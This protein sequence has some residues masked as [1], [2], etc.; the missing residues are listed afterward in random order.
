MLLFGD[1]NGDHIV[2]RFYPDTQSYGVFR[3]TYKQIGPDDLAARV[4]RELNDT[5]ELSGTFEQ[6]KAGLA[7]SERLLARM[8]GDNVG[9]I[10][11]VPG[12]GFPLGLTLP[13][14][15]KAQTRESID[16]KA[17]V[18]TY[19]HVFRPLKGS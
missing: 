16:E 19:R 5:P 3:S 18:C 10:V 12:V 2:K 17:L 4:R 15:E 1:E 13:P 8:A 9:R 6:T 11:P 14:K 7:S